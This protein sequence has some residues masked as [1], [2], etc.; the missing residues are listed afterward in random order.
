M[1]SLKPL[2]EK[3]LVICH[4]NYSIK[5]YRQIPSVLSKFLLSLKVS[6]PSNHQFLLSTEPNKGTTYTSSYNLNYFKF[7]VIA[8]YNETITITLLINMEILSPKI[9]YKWFRGKVLTYISLG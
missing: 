5:K 6:D 4:I 2:Y 7:L 1:D 3:L 8:I 9:I